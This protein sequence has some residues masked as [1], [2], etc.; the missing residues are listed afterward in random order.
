MSEARQQL[1]A[2]VHGQ[3]HGVNFRYATLSQAH[4]LHLTG[5]VRNVYDGTVEVIA[6]GPRSQ[7]ELLLQFLHSG[8]PSAHVTAVDARWRAETDGYEH[9]VIGDNL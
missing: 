2:I 4:Q 5:W 7:L 6:E 3:V 1:H 8:P 9:F